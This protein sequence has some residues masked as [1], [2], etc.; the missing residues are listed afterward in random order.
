MLVNLIIFVVSLLLVVKGSTM[1]TK[2]SAK[3]AQGFHLSKELV[4]FGIVALISILP[5]TLISINSAIEGMPEFGVGTLFGSNVADLC[6]I[7]GILVIYAGKGLK[8]S[9]RVL[10]D[11]HYYPLFLLI[12][13]IFG[14]N[15]RFSRL[16]G[17]FLVVAGIY[18]YITVYNNGKVHP[19][20]EPKR[21]GRIKSLFLLLFS[22][23]LLLVG[24]H[25]TV[26]SATAVAHI[27]HVAPLLVGM[28]V[29]SLGTTMP[30]LFYSLKSIKRKDDGLA[31]GDLMG[32]V[33]A[34]A[35]IVV[36][37]LALIAPF[38]FPVKII[39]ITGAFMLVSSLIVVWFMRS[40]RFV[41]RKEGL[42]LI[43]FW[44]LYVITEILLRD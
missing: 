27:L 2:Y 8:I 24:A 23:A 37:V 42:F 12:P 20:A 13:L 31:I 11:V 10:K 18:F 21:N 29:V 15:G 40:A 14:L 1:A 5:E 25:F 39:Y 22:M 34:D 32:T 17:V 36:G 41:S 16:E 43:G 26:T 38:N 44:A 4:G 19:K 35:T 3:L 28:L 30:E 33:L 7:F 9:S 6:L